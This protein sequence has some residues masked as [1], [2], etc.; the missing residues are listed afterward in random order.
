MPQ[1]SR[2]LTLLSIV[3]V[4]FFAEQDANA[5]SV[6]YSRIDSLCQRIEELVD[7]GEVT[8]GFALVKQLDVTLLKHDAAR[9]V[10]FAAGDVA[11]RAPLHSG[12]EQIL[13]IA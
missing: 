10:A 11:K 1:R 3:V 2:I 5:Q 12:F 8:T 4:L 13:F 9:L 6:A 7:R